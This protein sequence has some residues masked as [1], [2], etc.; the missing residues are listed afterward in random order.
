MKDN[1]SGGVIFLKSKRVIPGFKF[2]I[3]INSYSVI[4]VVGSLS[5]G[6]FDGI[7]KL[8]FNK[9]KSHEKYKTNVWQMYVYV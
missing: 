8:N 4:I 1:L 3:S 6:N 2:H 5:E 9:M 7:N